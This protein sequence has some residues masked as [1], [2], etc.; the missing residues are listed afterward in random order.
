MNK[1]TAYLSII[2]N[3]RCFI[4]SKYFDKDESHENPQKY[5]GDV[6]HYEHKISVHNL[7]AIF[8]NIIVT[9]IA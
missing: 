7:F 6:A 3:L 4:L 9:K 8:A 1:V 2:Q 5:T